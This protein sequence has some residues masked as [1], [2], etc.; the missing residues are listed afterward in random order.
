[1][2]SARSMLFRH[3]VPA[4]CAVAALL[5]PA[6]GCYYNEP[7]LSPPLEQFYYPTG[8][9]VSPGRNALYVAN[10]DFD[11]QYNGGT[12]DVLDLVATRATLTAI[13]TG[14]EDSAGHKINNGVRG[15]TC[16]QPGA[17][18]A[19][20]L[21]PVCN[22]IPVSSSTTP[23]E[24][25]CMS[26]SDCTSGNCV[27]GPNGQNGTCKACNVNADC[28]MSGYCDT[29]THA[30][31]L[32]V[33]TNTILSPSA[34]TPLA[35][36]FKQAQPG[37]TYGYGVVG[38][39]ASGAVLA[40]DQSASYERLFVPVRGDPSIT[41]FDVFDDTSGVG[42]GQDRLKLDCGQ[43][44]SNPR[45]DDEHRLG[46]DPYD[47]FRDLTLPVQ[48][49][50]L[51]VSSDGQYLVSAHQIMGTPA[52]GLSLNPWGTGSGPPPRPIFEF[53]LSGSSSVA[54]GPTEVA[55]IPMPAIVKAANVAYQPGFAVTYNQAAAIDIFRVD[56][57][58]ASHPPRPFLVRAPQAPITV[59]AN[60]TDSRGLVIDS[61]ERSDCESACATGPGA[62]YL[63]CLTSCVNVPLRLFVANRLPPTLLLGQIVTQVITNSAGPGVVTGVSDTIQF[64]DNVA[65]S[66][67]PSKVALGK[68]IN[69]LGQLQTFVFAVCFDTH[70][71]FMID[72]LQANTANA[73]VA[74]IPTGNGPNAIAF[75]TTCGAAPGA[76]CGAGDMAF[77]YVG[78]FL[79]SY[80]GVVDLDM[81]QTTFGTMFASI[82]TPIPPLE[83]Q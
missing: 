16:T 38:A 41:W 14:P 50:G 60:G 46:V 45:C 15:S 12:V 75:D 33:E 42:N 55:S 74:V 4:R 82:G 78:H 18:P 7:G 54:N 83:Q 81:R 19:A 65:L 9:A 67:G 8:L 68:A 56:S 47:N 21:S 69:Q 34:C 6:S 13:L 71:I 27:L 51:D 58:S 1:M 3:A 31:M 77:L 20:C 39:F 52:V 22:S 26:A 59:N 62:Q 35:P 57:D 30:C 63:S 66:T 36:A 10:S 5:L 80:L 79:E 23:N 49:V 28:V 40:R 53:Y 73:I 2:P 76:T 43:T 37:Q 32:A 11:L 48:P 70:R 64:Y 44:A 61:S 24:T 25:A 17:L 72:P 29:G